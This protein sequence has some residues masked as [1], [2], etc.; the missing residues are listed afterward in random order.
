MS[1]HDQII[2][3]L[4]DLEARSEKLSEDGSKFLDLMLMRV[5][6]GLSPTVSEAEILHDL[7]ERTQ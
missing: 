6:S 3:M 5:A 2:T 7:W 1:E 4:K